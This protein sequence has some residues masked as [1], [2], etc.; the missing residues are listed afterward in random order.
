MAAVWAHHELFLVASAHAALRWPAH[1]LDVIVHAAGE[2][3][4]HGGKSRARTAQR[5]EEHTVELLHVVLLE[6]LSGIP[7]EGTRERLR[8]HS[9]AA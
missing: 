4:C 8:A 5:I 1:V 3:R 7:A 9:G 6:R 2:L